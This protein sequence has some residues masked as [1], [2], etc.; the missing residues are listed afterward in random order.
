MSAQEQTD[1]VFAAYRAELEKLKKDPHPA[2]QAVASLAGGI[3][4]IAEALRN[5]L[6]DLRVETR[7]AAGASR[8]Y[9][10]YH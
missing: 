10:G 9:G 2:A 6:R 4:E 8:R 7:D 1:M 5:E 3:L